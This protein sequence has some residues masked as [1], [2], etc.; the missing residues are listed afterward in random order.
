MHSLSSWINDLATVK[1]LK[2]PGILDITFLYND[3]MSKV[4]GGSS[5]YLESR[6]KSWQF[7][8]KSYDKDLLAKST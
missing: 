8:M 6:F 7:V 1:G 4:I 2:Q 3:I 5:S